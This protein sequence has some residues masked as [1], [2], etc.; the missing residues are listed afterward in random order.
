M[1]LE[2]S[3]QKPGALKYYI[4]NNQ[5]PPDRITI[6]NW[7]EYNYTNIGSDPTFEEVID[8]ANQFDIPVY[9]INGT[10]ESQDDLHDS[11]NIRYRNVQ[12]IIHFPLY[13]LITFT[14]LLKKH[15]TNATDD[16][17]S[18]RYNQEFKHLFISLNN[19]P[20]PHRCAQMDMLAKNNLIENGAISWNSWYH[21][22]GRV[23]EKSYE[24]YNWEYW[25]PKLMILDEVVNPG[26]HAQL[27]PEFNHAFM[28]VVSESSDQAMFIT[29]KI[30]YPLMFNKL[31]LVSGPMGYHRLLEKLGFVLYD[32]LFDYSFDREPDFKN[33]FD[34]IAKNVL[35]YKGYTPYE[36]RNIYNKVLPKTIHNKKQLIRVTSD[37]SLWNKEVVEF[38]KEKIA[39][40]DEKDNCIFSYYRG[41]VDRGPILF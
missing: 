33:R 36:L 29:E 30:I 39:A 9:I 7:Q 5:T 6:I 26:W 31:F 1:N 15:V 27:P 4:E 20:H 10:D 24:Y 21:D 37:V 32:E 22:D 41:G 25:T 17:I 8:Y 2:I 16:P 18:V 23:L 34:L 28:Q 11:S 38:C 19:K 35:K 14:E 12:P 3:A 40:G 13:V